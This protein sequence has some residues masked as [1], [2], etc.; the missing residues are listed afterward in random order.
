[1][2]E[3]A[4]PVQVEALAGVS[5]DLLSQCTLVYVEEDPGLW[6]FVLTKM[7]AS[8]PGSLQQHQDLVHSSF[9]TLL[10][11]ALQYCRDAPRSSRC[12]HA[13]KDAAGAIWIGAAAM[14]FQA[15][16]V[17]ICLCHYS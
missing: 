9:S 2:T 10:P 16:S 11:A 7:A 1:M 5:P 4:C 6:E 13:R 3:L 12:G 14:L 17:H 15:V 8:L